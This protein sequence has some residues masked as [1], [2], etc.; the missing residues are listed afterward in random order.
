[1]RRL[2]GIA[3]L[4]GLLMAACSTETNQQA[5]REEDG[6]DEWRPGPAIQDLRFKIGSDQLD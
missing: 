1:M 6:Q 2:W 4:L 5:D 3:L